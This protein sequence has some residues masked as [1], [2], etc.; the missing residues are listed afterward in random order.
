MKI[1]KINIYFD[2]KI[3]FRQLQACLLVF[4]QNPSDARSALLIIGKLETPEDGKNRFL[5]A[6]HY[7]A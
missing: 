4:F 3:L 6:G 1:V 5:T 7:T 2:S